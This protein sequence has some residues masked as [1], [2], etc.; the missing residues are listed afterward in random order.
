MHF[1]KEPS[2]QLKFK[3]TPGDHQ[4]KAACTSKVTLLR[5]NSTCAAVPHVDCLKKNF[6]ITTMGGGSG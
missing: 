1:A 5:K 2:K 3:K 6:I 4:Y